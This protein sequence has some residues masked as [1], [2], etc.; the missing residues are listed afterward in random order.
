MMMTSQK[1]FRC[2]RYFRWASPLFLFNADTGCLRSLTPSIYRRMG[3]P[4]QRLL[5]QAYYSSGN[6]ILYR[7]QKEAT[8][9]KPL[10]YLYFIRLHTPTPLSRGDLWWYFKSLLSI[11]DRLNPTA[12]VTLPQLVLVTHESCHFLI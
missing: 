3:N 2:C 10:K 4:V 7:T 8:Y 5:Q 1:R 6:G 11:K 12:F 9:P